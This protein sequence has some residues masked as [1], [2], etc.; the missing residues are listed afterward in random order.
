MTILLS[1]IT[2]AAMPHGTIPVAAGKTGPQL[3]GAA[4]TNTMIISADVDPVSY[5]F[6]WAPIGTAVRIVQG[7]I[8]TISFLPLTGI[9]L[10]NPL[11]FTHSGGRFTEMVATVVSQPDATT[12]IWLLTGQMS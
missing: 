10:V 12:C 9:G 11:G 2:S 5:T 6:G 8:G 1:E 3:I 4:D 7:D